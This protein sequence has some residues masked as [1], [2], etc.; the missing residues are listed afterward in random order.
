MPSLRSA[1]PSRQ[2]EGSDPLLSSSINNQ[3]HSY[4]PLFC[5]LSSDDSGRRRVPGRGLNLR[6]ALIFLCLITASLKKVNSSWTHFLKLSWAFPLRLHLFPLS[7]CSYCTDDYFYLTFINT[8]PPPE[9]PG[10]I[11]LI[12]CNMYMSGRC[13]LLSPG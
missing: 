10:L 11:C 9:T 6:L 13:I 12:K 4:P 7:S 5:L 2:T 8:A 3:R 1:D